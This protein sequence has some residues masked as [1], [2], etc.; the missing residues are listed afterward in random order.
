MIMYIYLNKNNSYIYHNIYTL[1][2]LS[3]IY[4]LNYNINNKQL[5]KNLYNL[6]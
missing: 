5:I 3:M 1:F 6:Y 4:D 2:I